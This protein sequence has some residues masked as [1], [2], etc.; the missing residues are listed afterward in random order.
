MRESGARIENDATHKQKKNEKKRQKKKK[1]HFVFII[2]IS[3][4]D[5]I[6]TLK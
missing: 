1:K 4:S 3:Y 5:I 2:I 6:N